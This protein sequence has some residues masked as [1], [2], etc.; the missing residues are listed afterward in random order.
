MRK[1]LV[2]V[3]YLPRALARVG[4]PQEE[5]LLKRERVL[6]LVERL[7]VL[8]IGREEVPDVT[9]RVT[10]GEGHLT[11]HLRLLDVGL[12]Q[13]REVWGLARCPLCILD[14]GVRFHLRSAFNNISH[15][16]CSGT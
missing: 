7:Q 12:T 16:G 15:L 13:L 9:C 11:V 10:S 5:V 6:V 14:P 3:V 4:V 2:R 8:V 1:A